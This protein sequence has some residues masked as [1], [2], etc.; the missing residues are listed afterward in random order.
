[1]LPVRPIKKNYYLVIFAK[2]ANGYVT[3]FIHVMECYMLI[4]IVYKQL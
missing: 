1:M 2:Y 3:H 4:K